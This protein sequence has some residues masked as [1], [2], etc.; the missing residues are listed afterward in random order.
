MLKTP[1]M[2]MAVCLLVVALTAVIFSRNPVLI[3]FFSTVVVLSVISDKLMTRLRHIPPFLYSAAI[4]TGLIVGLIYSPGYP[5]HEALIAVII[6]VA[7]KNF[8]RINDRHIFNPAALGVMTAAFFFH[9]S[10]AWWSIAAIPSYIVLIPA[11]VSLVRL[12]RFRITLSFYIAYIALVWTIQFLH[13]S[14]DILPVI[15]NT[16]LNPATLFFSVVMLPEPMTSPNIPIRQIL[17]GLVTACIAVLSGLL[18]A[19][20]VAD[21][22]LAGLLAANALFFAFR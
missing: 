15:Q 1:K 4:V 19:V 9:R 18:S 16:L 2:L 22:L 8:L 5:W 12:K 14:E 6:A 20:Q 13:G 17:F 7:A 10:V 11:Y 3:A 21:P